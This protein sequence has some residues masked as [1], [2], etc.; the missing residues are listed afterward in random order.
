FGHAPVNLTKGIWRWL[1]QK[2]SLHVGFDAVFDGFTIHCVLLQSTKPV[3]RSKKLG[4]SAVD[5]E[6]LTECKLE[7][8][9]RGTEVADLLLQI[10][11][12]SSL[13]KRARLRNRP[14]SAADHVRCL[15]G[16]PCPPRRFHSE[17]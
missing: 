9:M 13:T 8:A 12:L 6:I 2:I 1:R 3:P 15:P 5:V 16:L 7:F 11:T 10:P 14:I 17:P 4:R